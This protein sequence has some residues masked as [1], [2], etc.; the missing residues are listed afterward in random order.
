[1]QITYE[2]D[3]IGQSWQVT[4]HD[5][6]HIERVLA[7]AVEPDPNAAIISQLAEIDKQSDSLRAKREAA[8]GNTSWLAELDARAAALR[9]QMVK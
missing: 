2:T 3:D 1:M 4:T 6:G 8:L 5:S 7:V 9:A